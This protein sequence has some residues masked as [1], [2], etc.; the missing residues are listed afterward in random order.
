MV[1]LYRDA[2]PRT[3]SGDCGFST[4]LAFAGMVVSAR[5]PLDGCP[6]LDPDVVRRCNAEL[7]EQYAAGKWTQR[8][9][10]DDALQWARE[11]S[12][13]MA[14]ADLPERIGGVLID[15]LN[16]PAL[17]L[18]YFDTYLIIRPSGCRIHRLLGRT[19]AAAALRG[20]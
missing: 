6:H 19:L 9:M 5:H 3:N 17:R 14:L 8:D 4:C 2:L 10:A 18:P 20:R 15:H 11:R 7:A 1:D 12:A 16:E 13:S